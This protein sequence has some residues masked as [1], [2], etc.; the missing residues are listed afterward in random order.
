MIKPREAPW[1]THNIKKFLRKKSRAY[2]TSVRKGQT[3]DKREGIQNMISD[4]ANIIED[5]K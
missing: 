2:E 3:G 1:V 4:G 5:A